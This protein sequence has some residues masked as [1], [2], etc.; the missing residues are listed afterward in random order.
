MRDS[1][2]KTFDAPPLGLTRPYGGTHK[3]LEKRIFNHSLYRSPRYFECT[4]GILSNKTRIF[5]R[6]INVEPDFEVDI[7]KACIVLHN[8]VRDRT[9]SRF[10]YLSVLYGNMVLNN[11]TYLTYIFTCLWKQGLA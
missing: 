6:P 4:F 7:V 3:T 8:F 10:H 11:V 1:S 2:R 5:H 9:N